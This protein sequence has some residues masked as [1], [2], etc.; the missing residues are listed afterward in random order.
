[1]YS[2]LMGLHLLCAEPAEGEQPKRILRVLRVRMC[3]ILAIMPF[4]SE[5]NLPRTRWAVSST[6]S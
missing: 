4:N 5:M 6:S 2:L 3:H 1:V